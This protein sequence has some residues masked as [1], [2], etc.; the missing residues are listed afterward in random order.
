[1]QEF[2][3]DMNPHNDFQEMMNAMIKAKES[4]S[5]IPSQIRAQFDND[6]AKFMD[7]VRNEE[8]K[9]QLID[10][11]LMNPPEPEPQPVQ[12]EVVNPAPPDTP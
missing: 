8:N 11:G 4:F 12:V 10:W 9:Q 6:P 2:E 1:M 3:F 5:S 7:F